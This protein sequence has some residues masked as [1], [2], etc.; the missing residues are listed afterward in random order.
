MVT[1]EDFFKKS[2]AAANRK[3]PLR[4]LTKLVQNRSPA[5]TVLACDAVVSD[6]DTN[7][8]VWQGIKSADTTGIVHRTNH[9][10]GNR[11]AGENLLFC[12][13]HVEWRNF[14]P[15]DVKDCIAVPSAMGD[16]DGSPYF[17]VIG[18]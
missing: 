1:A 11:P 6:R 3:P 9:L 8:K 5:G 17:W 15:E 7:P 2:A 12:D 16:P 18:P 4:L 14:P 10:Q 13:G